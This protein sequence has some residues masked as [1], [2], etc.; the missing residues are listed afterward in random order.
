MPVTKVKSGWTNGQLAF[1]DSTGSTGIRLDST[2]KALKLHFWKLDVTGGSTNLSI[3]SVNIGNLKVSSA[4]IAA[5]AITSGKLG[6]LSVKAAKVAAN[7]I[8]SSAVAANAIVAGKIK[9]EALDGQHPGFLTNNSTVPFIPVTYVV[10][11]TVKAAAAART[12]TTLKSVVIAERVRVIDVVIHQVGAAAATTEA[13]LR[14]R[15]GTNAL[16]NAVGVKAAADSIL[17]PATIDDAQ[18]YLAN[19]S[20]IQIRGEN[21]SSKAIP[22]CEFHIMC[23]KASA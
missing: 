12:T 8:A 14:V 16:T 21:A 10:R 23:L 7:A 15:R 6:A 22:A 4:K 5:S 9:D 19:A 20:T 13:T 11:T 3:T 2:G 1:R 18:W 17:R